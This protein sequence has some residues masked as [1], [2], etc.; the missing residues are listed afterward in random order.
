MMSIK[1]TLVPMVH[2]HHPCF[3]IDFYMCEETEVESARKQG[4]ITLQEFFQKIVA[5]RKEVEE[6]RQGW[7][8]DAEADTSGHSA[9]RSYEARW[10]MDQLDQLGSFKEQ[11]G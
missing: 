5:I 11:E 10:I 4:Y 6:R 2:P 3:Q 1:R 9:G 7:R 8:D